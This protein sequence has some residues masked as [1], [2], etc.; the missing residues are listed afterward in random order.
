MEQPN[1]AVGIGHFKPVV[2][3]DQTRLLVLSKDHIRMRFSSSLISIRIHFKDEIS[4][5]NPYITINSNHDYTF[6]Y[7]CI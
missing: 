5:F 6:E 1:S 4:T 7:N 3:N 2:T